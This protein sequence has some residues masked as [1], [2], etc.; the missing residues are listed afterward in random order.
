MD[1]DEGP[2]NVHDISC[3]TLHDTAVQLCMIAC[4]DATCLALGTC[5][6][7]AV[8]LYDDAEVRESIFRSFGEVNRSQFEALSAEAYKDREELVIDVVLPHVDIVEYYG[9]EEGPSAL[10]SF[11]FHPRLI[12]AL[13]W[14]YWA[15]SNYKLLIEKGRS[16]TYDD[17]L[18]NNLEL[19]DRRF[20][21]ELE[22]YEL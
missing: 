19:E 3:Q 20:E 7:K 4:G 1:Q 13:P 5:E 9:G 10:L 16:S 14:A 11:Q 17:R 21:E 2:V 6:S 15:V 8:E 18:F 12:P 22:A